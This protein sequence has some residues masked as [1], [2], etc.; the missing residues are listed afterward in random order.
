MK[1]NIAKMTA[2]AALVLG[3]ASAAHAANQAKIEF[4]GKVVQTACDI[5][6]DDSADSSISLGA[7]AAEE[8]TDNTSV[9]TMHSAPIKLD[10]GSGHDCKGANIPAAAAISLVADQQGSIPTPVKGA[11]L[12]GDSDLGVGIDLQGAVWNSGALPTTY[13]AITPSTGLV[14]YTNTTDA[15]VSPDS[16]ELPAAVFL[17]AGLRAY[18]AATDISSGTVH[19]SVT[20]TAAYE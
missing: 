1:K 9:H 2:A 4:E 10:L 12:F 3:M 6:L 19:S 7:F 15:A 8:F 11:N 14:L 16:I 13:T 17:K 5:S 20:F 18:E